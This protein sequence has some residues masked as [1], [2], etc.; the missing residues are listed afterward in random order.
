MAEL[1]DVIKACLITSNSN[2][3]DACA[4]KIIIKIQSRF[5][6]EQ[7]YIPNFKSERILKRN[8]E[9]LARFN[10]RNHSELAQLFDLS[11]KQVYQIIKNSRS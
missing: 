7:I 5:C 2:D 4:S 8:S 1:Y 3:V 11:L 6:G 9:L 10:G